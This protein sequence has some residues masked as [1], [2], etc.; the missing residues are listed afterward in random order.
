MDPQVQQRLDTI[1]AKLDA[2][3]AKVHKTYRMFQIIMWVTI[4]AFV[5][6]AIGLIFAIPAFINSYTS[7]LNG[8]I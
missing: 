7:S 3:Y 6:P 1:E 4:I 8:L 5:L 2:T